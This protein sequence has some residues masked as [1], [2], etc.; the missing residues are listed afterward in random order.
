MAA[1]VD[2]LATIVVSKQQE[3]T[4]NMT[5]PR[6]HSGGH[7]KPNGC[8]DKPTFPPMMEVNDFVVDAAKEARKNALVLHL[9]YHHLL[10]FLSGIMAACF[11]YHFPW[12]SYNNQRQLQHLPSEHYLQIRDDFAIYSKEAEQQK[13]QA[14]REFYG[15]S[16]AEVANIPEDDANTKEALATLKLGQSMHKAGKE[17]KAQRLFEHAYALAPKN[18]EVLL[19]Y[20]EYL[21]QRDILLADQYYYQV[22]SS[23]NQKH[24]RCL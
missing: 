4:A 2:I 24:S 18:P 22:R 11:Y 17:E 6:R 1:A 20:G 5:K 15:E 10:V 7:H 9:T 16:G 8:L 21:E 23:S 13:Q 14:I 19:R 12:T 3:T